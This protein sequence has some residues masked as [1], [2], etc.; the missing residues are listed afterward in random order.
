VHFFVVRN[1][2]FVWKDAIT[3]QQENITIPFPRPLLTHILFYVSRA[4]LARLHHP[5]PCDLKISTILASS[6]SAAASTAPPKPSPPPQ[7]TLYHL[8]THGERFER[9]GRGGG[10]GGKNII[11]Y[12]HI[13]F[14]FYF[15]TLARIISL[16]LLLPPLVS[17]FTKARQLPWQQHGWEGGGEGGGGGSG[18]V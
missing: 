17:I 5:S 18:F 14:Y 12:Y 13:Y 11:G 10:G 16:T 4:G 7:L 1:A 2:S 8:P 15:S 3:R 9:G 6:G